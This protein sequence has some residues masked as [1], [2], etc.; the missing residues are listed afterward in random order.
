MPSAEG[1]KAA[2]GLQEAG[3]IINRRTIILGTGAALAAGGG[4]ALLLRGQGPCEAVSRQTIEWTASEFRA[5]G[6]AGIP[7][8]LPAPVF[9]THPQYVATLE[10]TLGPCH[11]SDV[12]VRT[13]ISEGTLGLPTRISLRAP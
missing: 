10:K 7:A 2:M 13:D 3:R 4:A 12:P 8:D 1:H 9:P 11:T 5:G 6:T